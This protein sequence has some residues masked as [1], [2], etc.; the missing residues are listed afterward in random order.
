MR[1][2]WYSYSGCR[3]SFGGVK[4]RLLRDVYGQAYDLPPTVTPAPVDLPDR[5]RAGLWGNTV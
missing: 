3:T 2:D 4:I 1:S 5:S